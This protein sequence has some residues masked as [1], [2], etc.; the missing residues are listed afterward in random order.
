MKKIILFI[1]FS[2]NLLQVS[3]DTILS[4]WLNDIECSTE[5]WTNSRTM[6]WIPSSNSSN[7]AQS[8]TIT[9]NS[10][11]YYTSWDYI[12]TF[13]YNLWQ[14]W[15]NPW[16][17]VIDWNSTTWTITC[18]KYDDTSPTI[19]DITN[20]NYINLLADNIYNY[21]LNISEN[22]WSPITLLEWYKEN[23]NNELTVDSFSDSTLP[24][25]QSWNIS[26]VDNYKIANWSRIYTFW[27]TKM[28]DEAWNCWEWMKSYDHNVYPNSLNLWTKSVSVNELDDW[29]IADWTSKN[30]TISL[31]DIFWN[32]IT[33]A[34]W[35]WREVSFNFNTDNTTYLNQYLK[36]WNWVFLNSTT[37]TSNY[38]NRILKWNSVSNLFNNQVSSN[39]NYNYWF[40]V[41]T[42]T[43]DS[44][45]RAYWNLIFNNITSSITDS[46]S[47]W[48]NNNFTINWWN[49]SIKFNPLYYTTIFWDTINDWFIEWGVQHSLI[50]LKKNLSSMNPTVDLCLEFGSWDINQSQ[51]SFNLKYWINS[52]NVTNLIWEW[53]WNCTNYVWP[54][55]IWDN[56]FYTKLTLNP[57]SKLTD[58]Q[59]WYLSTHLSYNIDW[60]NI[61]YNSDIFWKD[62][63]Y[64]SSNN[65]YWA[66][67][68]WGNTYS[69]S[70]KVLWNTYSQKYNE[71]QEWQL[72]NEVKLLNWNITKAWI[73]KDIRNNAYSMIKTISASNWWKIINNLD[74]ANN[75]D[76]S[77]LSQNN[78]LYF[79]WLNWE[80][81]ILESWVYSW[82]KT[83]VIEWGNIV[84]NW[85]IKALNNKKDILWIIV[86]KNN[87]WKWWNVYI[88]PSVISIESVIYADK[89]LIS[90][91]WIEL[92]WDSA[93][94][95]LRNQLYIYWSVFSEN[96][97]W[98]SRN[99]VPICPYYVTNICNLEEAQKYDLNYLRRYMTKDTNLDWIPDTP[100]SLWISYFN[101]SSSYFKY[102]V[103]ISYNPII[104]TT[105]PPLFVK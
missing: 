2:I 64:S 80:N 72:W 37:D 93:I 81:V 16:E 98:W 82:R 49:F 31:L 69:E 34:S 102:P 55:W 38:L 92:W 71:I 7:N 87:E 19:A 105:P 36:T 60:K 68:I 35:I 42:P 4:W 75:I 48:N 18:R 20:S 95:Y 101:S 67:S 41:Y 91:N 44:Y 39:W 96:T 23:Q 76:W 8:W 79:G 63:I 33:A 61:F 29:E 52:S 86:L 74:F 12:K 66:S 56:E 28:C 53:N 27:V 24:I 94:D 13:S 62:I 11:Y 90:Y 22:W 6:Y 46:I 45:I 14:T 50:N 57:W 100:V 9:C 59:K 65:N 103:V 70:L 78:I 43:Q 21:S 99:I 88:N 85:N 51:S 58:L 5:I 104:Q 26:K 47:L 17:M 32:A 84:I 15:C 3:A 97:I 40:R 83:I 25:W 10:H 73:K 89:S 77:K 30:L 54:L 1:L